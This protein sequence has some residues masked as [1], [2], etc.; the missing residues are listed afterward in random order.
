[1]CVF[2]NPREQTGKIVGKTMNIL[3]ESAGGV[4]KGGALFKTA[5]SLEESW[6]RARDGTLSWKP[7]GEVPAFMGSLRLLY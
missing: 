5:V 3:L 2:F 1:L 6:A 7:V 4:V